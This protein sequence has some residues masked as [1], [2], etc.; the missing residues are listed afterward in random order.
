VSRATAELEARLGAHNFKEERILYP[1]FERVV[2][3]GARAALAQQVEAL[4]RA[5]E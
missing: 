5:S 3:P 2:A 4:L 1:A